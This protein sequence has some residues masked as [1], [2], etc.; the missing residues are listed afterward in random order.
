MRSDRLSLWSISSRQCSLLTGVA[1]RDR[2]VCGQW[3]NWALERA[4]NE[5]PLLPLKKVMLHTLEFSLFA[6]L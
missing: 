5:A 4:M 2:A 3:Q 6:K 1:A